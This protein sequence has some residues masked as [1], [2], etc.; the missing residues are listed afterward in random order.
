M[1]ITWLGQAGLL[2]E[3]DGTTVM[4]DPYLS[5]SVA[6]TDPTKARRA[7]AEPRFWEI[8]PDIMLFTHDHIDHYDPETAPHFL[9]RRSGMTVL[10]PSS[11]WKKA[12]AEGGGHNYVQFDRMTEWTEHGF[13]FLAVRAVHSDE[14][15]VGVVIEDL[16]EQKVYYVAGDT[17]YSRLVLADLPAKIDAAFLPI[18]GV[19]NNMNMDDA[20][21]FARECGAK[22]V[23]PLHF[24]L[25]DD[26]DPAKMPCENKVIPEIFREIPL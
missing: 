23:V 3:R 24:G 4:I 19:G 5:D 1:K 13:R 11:V 18:N 16:I 10:C 25:F 21:R 12:R 8:T 17:L 6:K 22:A 9:R 2:F 20:A 26:I 15:A 7:P 14:H